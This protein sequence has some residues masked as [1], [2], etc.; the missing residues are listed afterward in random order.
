MVIDKRVQE[1]QMR[2]QQKETAQLGE[3]NIGGETH[4]ED[5]V[6]ATIASVAARDVEGVSS[7]GARSLRRVVQEAFGGSEDKG[8]G[9]EVEAGR[10]EA[11]LDLDLRIEYGYSIPETVIKVREAVANRMLELAGLLAKEININ[12]TAIDFQ[13][14]DHQP[15]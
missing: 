11:I 3:I 4:I 15:E 10:K 14:D 6:L 5:E 8:R 13:A 9:V 7:L 2:A 1:Q 12:V